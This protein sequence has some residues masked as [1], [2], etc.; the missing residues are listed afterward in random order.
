MVASILLASSVLKASSVLHNDLVN[1]VLRLP[2]AFFDTTPVGRLLNRF[3]KDVDTIDNTLPYN[4]RGW[5]TT[6]LQV[7]GIF[8]FNF[9]LLF[10]FFCVYVSLCLFLFC[11]PFFFVFLFFL[12]LFSTISKQH[13]HHRFEV[14]KDV[15][16][17]EGTFK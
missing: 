13:H 17:L 10:P 15:R 4:L 12:F 6:L 7:L 3:S 14:V 2:M 5:I 9:P 11:F 16:K 1:S 8:Q